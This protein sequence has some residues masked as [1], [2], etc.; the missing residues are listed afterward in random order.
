MVDNLNTSILPDQTAYKLDPES[1]EAFE[2]GDFS[3]HPLVFTNEI[4]SYLDVGEPDA[5]NPWHTHMPT[6]DQLCFCIAGRGRF[7]IEQEEGEQVIETEPGDLVYLP[8][9]AHHRV[10]TI[11]DETFKY[12]AVNQ[13][14]R[15][16]RLE[17]LYED[18]DE[19]VDYEDWPVTLWVDRER[20]EILAKNDDAVDTE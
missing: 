6:Y 4:H 16:G 9:G 1:A 2:V 18:W 11:G 5:V 17:M 13:S 10:E 8:G 20:D 7:R 3:M 15:L 19:F 14:M 12:Y